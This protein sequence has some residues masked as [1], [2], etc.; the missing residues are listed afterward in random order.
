MGSGVEFGDIWHSRLEQWLNVEGNSKQVELINFAVDQYGL[1]QIVATL[2]QK[3]LAYDPDLIL[4]AITN[5]TPHV[6]WTDSVEAYVVADQ[7]HPFFELHSLRVMDM[8]LQLGLMDPAPGGRVNMLDI[9][10]SMEE[11]KI[12]AGQLE[13]ISIENDIPIALVK[14]AYQPRWKRKNK[15]PPAI[16]PT[17]PAF[18]YIDV[19]ERV[20]NSGYKPAEL[21]VSVWDSHP[22]RLAHELMAK[23]ILEQMLANNLLPESVNA[24]RSVR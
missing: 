4:I 21:S 3:A 6:P 10:P 2:E 23:A 20:R 19:T 17:H 5:Y 11:I 22:N 1:G 18:I 13:A 9:H 15:G 16:L 12:A 14:L 24:G 8:R 7:R